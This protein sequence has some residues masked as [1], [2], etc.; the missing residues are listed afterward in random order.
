MTRTDRNPTIWAQFKTKH[1]PMMKHLMIFVKPA[2][3]FLEY[4]CPDLPTGI[5]QTIQFW[6]FGNSKHTFYREAIFK[7]F[8]YKTC[9][10]KKVQ[11]LLSLQTL[12]A[13]L[14]MLGAPL[15]TLEGLQILGA[16]VQILGA[17]FQTL[18]GP[19]PPPVPI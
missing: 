18:G 1:K 19:A 15:Q 8:S 4:K 12:R 17:L 5:V 13:L 2:S 16:L 7:K 14:Q 6:F 3:I 9:V 10:S 11:I